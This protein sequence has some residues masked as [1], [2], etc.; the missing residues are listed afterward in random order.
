M[1]YGYIPNN[2]NA[3]TMPQ[4]Q[5][6]QQQN[7]G[8]I[9]VQGIEAMKSYPVAPGQSVLLMDSESNC[10]GIKTADVSGMPLP[11]RIFDYSEIAEMQGE[12][13]PNANTCIKLAAYYTILNELQGKPDTSKYSSAPAPEPVKETVDYYS[14]TEFG[15]L[16]QDKPV[17]DVMSVMDELISVLS[18]IQPRLYNGVMRKL[19]EL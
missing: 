6:P 8:L 14:E 9:W 7:N 1:P 12:R 4:Y 2:Y 19:N 18:A 3:Y 15:R 17:K 13:N 5:Q 11:L 16:V 10:F